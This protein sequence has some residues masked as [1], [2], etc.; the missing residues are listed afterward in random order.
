MSS[1]GTERAFVSFGRDA[2]DHQ[3]CKSKPDGVK[4]MGRG[5]VQPKFLIVPF[6]KCLCALQRDAWERVQA[7]LDKPGRFTSVC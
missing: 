5:E 4:E 2:D 7:G 3:G 6:P 1:I